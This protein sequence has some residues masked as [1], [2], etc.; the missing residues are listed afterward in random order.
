MILGRTADNK[1]KIKTDGTTR[2]V[3]CACCVPPV[4]CTEYDELPGIG[5]HQISAGMASTLL[6]ANIYADLSAS[7]PTN[8]A[9]FQNVLFSGP[10]QP[11]PGLCYYSFTLSVGEEESGAFIASLDLTKALG[12]WY[13]FASAD[14]FLDP[15]GAMYTFDASCPESPSG[16]ITLLGV[17]IP[18]FVCAFAEEDISSFT[19]DIHE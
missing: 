10:S 17:S 9:S 18:S 1:I 2:A 3:N 8:S 19:V 11:Y 12:N 13:I 7:S 14:V 15:Y 5:Y 16:S 4:V 6:S